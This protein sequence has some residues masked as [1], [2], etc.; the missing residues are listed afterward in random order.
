MFGHLNFVLFSCAFV[1]RNS[2]RGFALLL[3][4]VYHVVFWMQNFRSPSMKRSMVITNNRVFCSF[5]KGSVSKRLRRTA[6]PTT[7]RYKGADGKNR[8]VGTVRLKKSQTLAI[9][10]VFNMLGFKY[11]ALPKNV[12]WL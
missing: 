7:K 11:C 1:Q 2:F 9:I 3:V 4:E 12:V 10:C 6:T 8:F 5:D